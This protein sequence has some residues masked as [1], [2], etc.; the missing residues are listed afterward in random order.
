MTGW[1]SIVPFFAAVVLVAATGAMFMPGEWYLTLEKPT[2]TPPGWVFGPAWT[3]LYV[4]IAIAG[5]LVWQAGGWSAALT[6]WSLN[7]VFNAAWSWLMFGRHEIGLAL[8]DALAMLVT[9]VV[10]IALTWQ[11]VPRAA[12]LFLPY[13]GWVAFATALNYAIWLRNPAAG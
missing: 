7:L 5:W 9:I 3:L 13:L 8:L 6:V 4:M 1:L 12:L 2:W 10:F 11:S